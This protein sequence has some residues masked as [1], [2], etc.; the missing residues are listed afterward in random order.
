[1]PKASEAIP[2]GIAS[3][4]AEALIESMKLGMEK[5]EEAETSQTP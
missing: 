1:M 4:M 5:L 2:N 3:I